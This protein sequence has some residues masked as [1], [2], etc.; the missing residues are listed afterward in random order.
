MSDKKYKFSLVLATL[1]R[2][3]TVDRFLQTLVDQQYA[4]QTVQII[5]V[6]QNGSNLLDN[7]IAKHA[8]RLNLVHIRSARRGLSLNRNI[9]LDR[10]EGEI[11]GFPDDDCEYPRDLLKTVEA[12]FDATSADLLLGKIWDPQLDKPA[13]RS[14]P[15]KFQSLNSF[16]FYRLTSSITLF[17]K[18]VNHR[19][20]ERFGLGAQFGSNEDVIFVYSLLQN[21]LVGCYEPSIRVYHEDQ[22][23]SALNEEKV[24]GYAFGFGRFAREYLSL[25]VLAIFASSLAFQMLHGLKAICLFDSKAAR[26]RAASLGA[27][28]RGFLSRA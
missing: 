17:T 4:L 10:A 7:V 25:P 27:R 26:L 12:T 16:N 14:W 24:A 21:G 18:S 2:R 5:I 15:E 13:I 3:D 6:D 8:G 23:M 28:F 9:G 20:D 22:P 11:V 1:G 19:F